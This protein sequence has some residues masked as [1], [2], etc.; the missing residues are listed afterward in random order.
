MTATKRKSPTL[1]KGV[2]SL[3][4]GDKTIKVLLNYLTKHAKYGKMMKRRTVAHVHDEKNETQVGDT[5]EIC[6]CLKLSKSK[7]WRLVRILE[8]INQ[9]S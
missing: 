2:V 8:S 7:S 3:K 5:V 1:Y 9:T 6:K 4:S